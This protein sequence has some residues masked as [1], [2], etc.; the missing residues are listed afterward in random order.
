MEKIEITPEEA[1]ARVRQSFPFDNYIS[2]D[3][4]PWMTV[5]R[6]LAGYMQPGQSLFDLGAGACDKTAIASVMGLDCTACDDLG[7]DWYQKG[8]N[9][10]RIEAFARE[11]NIRFSR[12]FRPPE[13]GTF[14]MVMMND[15]LEH[16]HDSP[17]LLLNRLIE[18]LKTG[19]LLFITVP[20]LANIRKR[21]DLMRGRTN[22]ANYDLYYWYEGPWRGPQRE[23]VRSDLTAMCSHLGVEIVELGTVHHMLGNLPAVAHPVYKA[24]TTLFPD[25]RDTWLLVARKP[26]GWQPKTS[27]SQAEFARIYGRKGYAL[28]GQD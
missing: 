8:D 21:L 12:E 23:Y 24:V 3:L 15:V 19:G 9:I 13:P 26:A 11:M 27:I 10:E 18:G 7:D 17:R 22:L 4:A 16:I 1:L 25:W 14:D 2:G 20:N 28:Y 6:T 5:G